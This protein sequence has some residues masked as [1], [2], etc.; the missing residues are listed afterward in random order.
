MK[1][2]SGTPE[3]IEEKRG[4]DPYHSCYY[5]GVL[6][7]QIWRHY[8]RTHFQEKMVQDYLAK[9]KNSKQRRLLT[10]L[11]RKLGDHK[12]NTGNSIKGIGHKVGN[13]SLLEIS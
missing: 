4:G 11:L 8:G 9:P 13:V 12:H 5:C 3:G 2:C 7:Q 6:V 1:Y 10:T